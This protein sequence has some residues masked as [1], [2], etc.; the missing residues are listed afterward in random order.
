VSKKIVIPKERFDDMNIYTRRYEIRYRIVS[1]DR[2]RFSAWSN[3]YSVDPEIIFQPGTFDIPGYLT[4][5]KVGDSVNIT[6]DAVSIYKK[7]NESF[8][9]IGQVPHYDVWVKW[10]GNSGANPSDWIYQERI[11]STSFFVNVPAS[12][13]D[14]TGATRTSPKYLYVEV[15]RPGRPILRFEETRSFPQNATIVN[16]TN[17]TITFPEGHGV[18][19]GTPGLYLSSNPIGGLSDNTTYYVRMVDYFTISLHPTQSD[20]LDNTNK[21]SLTGTPSGTGSFTGFTF[22]IYDSVITTL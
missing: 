7:I 2:N 18:I 20:A 3:I 9:Y 21:I 22:R 16:T 17:D 19:T 12:Y 6:W 4:L 8:D 1:D 13:V 14:S 15:Y 10:A 11:S 5:T